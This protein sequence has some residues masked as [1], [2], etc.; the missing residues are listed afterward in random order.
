MGGYELLQLRRIKRANDLCRFYISKC[1]THCSTH[2]YLI[3][4]VQYGVVRVTL[5]L[6]RTCAEVRR[7]DAKMFQG[8]CLHN[9]VVILCRLDVV[10]G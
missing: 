2:S 1:P 5:E 10:Q 3:Q 4:G 7:N 8:K 9:I 6:Q